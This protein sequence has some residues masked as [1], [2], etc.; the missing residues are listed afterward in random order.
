MAI[1][2]TIIET[3]IGPAFTITPASDGKVFGLGDTPDQFS[4][5]GFAL[6]FVPDGEFAGTITIL[7]RHTDQDA[8]SANVQMVPYPFRAFYLNDAIADITVMQ[9]SGTPITGRSD[10][11]IPASGHRIGIQISC[12]QGTCPVYVQAVRGST[13]P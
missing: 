9:I 7:G 6:D 11:L 4:T 12:S 10:L 5:G 1:A 2:T 8:V 3:N 13:A